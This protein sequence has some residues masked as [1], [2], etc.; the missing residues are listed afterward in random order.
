MSVK[1]KDRHKSN[2]E[3]LEKSRR[4]V[5]QIL[6][7]VRQAEYDE[8]GKRIHKAGILG[9][10]QPLQVFGLDLIRSGKRIH[11]KCYEGCKIYLKDKQSWKMRR[12][13]FK[14]AIE[15]CDSIFR[16]LDLCI[17]QYGSSQKKR[18]SFEYLARL[19]KEAKESIQ[20]RLNRDNLIYQHN[21]HDE[22]IHRRGR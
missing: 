10:G 11:A 17:S 9:E 6:I 20:D 8:S 12:M 14:E 18:K 13:Y 3:P 21:Y 4:L 19:T 15:Q 22:I 5:E 1:K 2:Q 7:L 16:Q